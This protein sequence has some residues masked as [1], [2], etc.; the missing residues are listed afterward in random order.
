MGSLAI[1]LPGVFCAGGMVLCMWLMS[2][3]RSHGN[4]APTL[5][6]GD[7]GADG[8]SEL[9]QLREELDRLRAR[10]SSHDVKAD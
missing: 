6:P 2:R 3:G 9:G 10:V 8:Q 4:K 1:Y 5:S 7:Q